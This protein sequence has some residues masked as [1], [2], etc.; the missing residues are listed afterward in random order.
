MKTPALQPAG[1]LLCRCISPH[2]PRTGPQFWK[3]TAVLE[4]ELSRSA[5][6]P[7]A[8]ENAVAAAANAAKD[9]VSYL[10]MIAE[11]SAFHIEQAGES[12][13][14]YLRFAQ[15]RK[16]SLETAEGR[17]FLKDSIIRLSAVNAYIT[18]GMLSVFSHMNA[19]APE[20][21]AELMQMLCE[22]ESAVSAGESPAVYQTVKQILAAV[23]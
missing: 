17:A 22:I 9:T 3:R 6:H 18:V 5:A 7:L 13:S 14:L 11:S 19:C 12:R 16:V 8:F 1:F 20:L 23:E 21:K 15:N 10:Q 2:L 4:A